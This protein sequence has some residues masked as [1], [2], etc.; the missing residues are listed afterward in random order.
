MDENEEDKPRFAKLTDN[1]NKI[2]KKK[3]EKSKFAIDDG[4]VELT[5]EASANLLPARGGNIQ[6]LVLTG[7]E[8]RG[9]HLE[10][11]ARKFVVYSIEITYDSE[12]YMVFRR[13]KQFTT[14]RTELQKRRFKVPKLPEKRKGNMF[15]T[16]KIDIEVL[17]SR[18][19]ELQKW[20][21]DILAIPGVAANQRLINWLKPM[22]IGDIKAKNYV[23]NAK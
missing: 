15:G 21:R 5:S 13:Y 1:T 17:K 11:S 7:C 19:P 12:T 2:R 10:S 18:I 8:T 20:F 22:Q 6:H 16:K 3:G 14:I 4:V 9:E 23:P